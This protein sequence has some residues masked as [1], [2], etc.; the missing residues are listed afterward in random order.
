MD[1]F[2]ILYKDGVAS[3]PLHPIDANGWVGCGWSTE[4]VPVEPESAPKKATA[5][6]VTT[7]ES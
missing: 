6:K 1:T 2:V 3:P 4:D 7:E 5:K